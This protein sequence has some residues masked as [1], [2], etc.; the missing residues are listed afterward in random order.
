VFT[1]SSGNPTSLANP[2]VTHVNPALWWFV[3]VAFVAAFV[4]V[5]WL[6]KI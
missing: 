6:V 3:L 5:N 1:R 4:L 2:F